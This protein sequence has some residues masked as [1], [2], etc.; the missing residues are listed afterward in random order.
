M[1]SCSICPSVFGIFLLCPQVSPKL[2]QTAGFPSFSWLNNIPLCIYMTHVIYW[3]FRSFPYLGY[4]EYCCNEH[5]NADTSLRSWFR[6][7]WIYIHR[8]G[9]AEPYDSSIFSF[10]GASILFLL[11]AAKIYIPTNIVQRFPLLHILT[12]SYNFWLFLIKAILTDV[13]RYLTGVLIYISLIISYVEHLFM[14]FLA[15]CMSSLEKCLCRSSAIF[16]LGSLF[17]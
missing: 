3:T 11:V 1:V 5:V 12:N 13:R 9:I 8:S 6:F 7:H 14:C 16:G 4:C 15:I 17:F 2:S 10:S